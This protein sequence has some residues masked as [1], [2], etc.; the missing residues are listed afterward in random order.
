M[1]TNSLITNKKKKRASFIKIK[2]ITDDFKLNLFP[3][4][5]WLT[6]TTVSIIVKLF[7]IFNKDETDKNEIKQI[8]ETFKLVIKEL[9]RYPPFKLV[10]IESKNKTIIIQTK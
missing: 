8:T 3:I 2:I 1:E 10:E 6:K 5:L 7:L 9:K 4:P